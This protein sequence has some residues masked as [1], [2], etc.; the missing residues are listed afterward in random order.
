[1]FTEALIREIYHNKLIFR[2]FISGEA[3]GFWIL[4]TTYFWIGLLCLAALIITSIVV[5]HVQI[6]LYKLVS[7]DINV[8]IWI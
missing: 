7:H 8:N 6:N 1:M 2:C 3:N 5:A 4:F